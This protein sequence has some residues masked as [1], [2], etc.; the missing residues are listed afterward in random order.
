V[1]AFPRVATQ[2]MLNNVFFRVSKDFCGPKYSTILTSDSDKYTNIYVDFIQLYSIDMSIYNRTSY[3]Q[4]N[5]VNDW[6]SRELAPGVRPVA[7]LSDPSV[8]VS[9]ADAR[10][11]VYER[12]PSDSTV[13]LKGQSFSP[14]QL[15]GQD[16]PP[17]VN[18]A[19]LILRLAPQDYHRFH[20]PVTGTILSITSLSGG[21]QSVNADAMRAEDD[22]IYNERVSVFIQTPFGQV[23]FV[24][25]GAACVGSIQVFPAVGANI[26]KGQL[27][28]TFQFG[29]ST[30]AVMFEANRLQWDADV[31]TMSSQAVESLVRMGQRMGRFVA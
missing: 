2:M 5:S 17:F 30:C 4:Y 27:L 7:D 15:V 18:G 9:G 22:A 13:W 21:L 14:S 16:Y 12:V 20:T 6:F 1:Y 23:A 25:L 31:A 29:G 3:T 11:V 19:L 26:T 10:V 24:A 8:V 28:G